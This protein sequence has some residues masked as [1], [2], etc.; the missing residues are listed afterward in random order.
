MILI[1]G[2]TSVSAAEVGNLSSQETSVTSSE[3]NS[4]SEE[5]GSSQDQTS[6]QVVTT[7]TDDQSSDIQSEE[8]SGSDQS[9]AQSTDTTEQTSDTSDTQSVSQTEDQTESQTEDQSVSQT[10]DQTAAQS[11][12]QAQE[13]SETQTDTQ[14]DE[15]EMPAQNFEQTSDSGIKVAVS[16]PEGAFP[17]GT[18]MEVADVS[19][20]T[21]MSIAKEGSD[22]PE[23]VVDA[24][25][26]D[27]TFK[28]K[29]GQE[30]E[31]ADGKDISVS[32]TLAEDLEGETFNVVHDDEQAGPTEIADAT[33]S[34]ASFTADSFSIYV[35]DGESPAIATY[36]FYDADGNLLT[37]TADGVTFSEQ[38]I[39]DGETLYSP[40]NPEKTGY[41]FQG[42]TT[43]QGSSTVELEP[44]SS[45]TPE[46]T[47]TQTI[48]YYP[49]FEEAHYVFFMDGT[50]SDARVYQTKSGVSG[51]EIDTT[52][53]TLPSA[54]TSSFTGWYTD[55]ALTN[56]AGD[57]VTL[58]SENIYLYPKFEEGHYLIF[59][60]GDDAT[61]IEPEFVASGSVTTEP[62]DP[63][64]AGY[65]FVGWSTTE[66][67]TTADFTF[68]SELTEDTT[69]YA[70][71]EPATTTYTVLFW[72]Q[73]VTD[74][75]NAADADKTYE[76]WTSATRTGTTESYAEPTSSDKAKSSVNDGVG[77]HF[78]ETNSVSVQIKGDGS[79][80]L[81]IYYDRDL[82]TYNFYS[83]GFSSTP[84]Y[85]I[86]GLYGATLKQSG[87]EWPSD[88]ETVWY[89][90]NGYYYSY[91]DD[92]QP[93]KDFTYSGNS[94]SIKFY[95]SAGSRTLKYY[96]ESV[97]GGGYTDSLT[98][99]TFYL[100]AGDGT[101]V[102]GGWNFENIFSGFTVSQF[103]V[104]DS[105]GNYGDWVSVSSDGSTTLSLN[106]M[107]YYS[108]HKS[109]FSDA[110]AY[111]SFG[112]FDVFYSRNQHSIQYYSGNELIHTESGIYYE[113]SLA[114]YG[115]DGDNYYVPEEAPSTVVEGSVF[116]GWY[117]DPECTVPYDFASATMPDDNVIVYAKWVE[118]T[119]NAYVYDEMYG[120]DL[121]DTIT[122]D[123]GGTVDENLMPNV[124][125]EDGNYYVY[126]SSSVTITI[127][128]DS[129]WIG[130]DV[131][132][133]D[134]DGNTTSYETYSF[135]TQLTEDIYL[136]PH[137]LVLNDYHITYD[138][139][140][141]TGTVTDSRNYAGGDDCYADVMS[142]SNLTPPEGKVFLYWNTAA[143]GSGTTYY[144][145]DQILMNSDV[146]LYAIYGDDPDA[147]N[148]TYYSNYPSDANLSEVTTKHTVNGETVLLN[149]QDLT[150]YTL[151]QASMST[152]DG[153]VFVGWNTAEDGS[154]TSYAAG[155]TI[156]VDVNDPQPNALYAIWV[157]EPTKD[158]FQSSDTSTS[159]DGDLVE[160]GDEL[161]YTITYTNSTGS[162]ATVTITDSIPE[163]ST[164]V[165][166]SAD[167]GGT[168]ADGT[169]TWNLTVADGDSI[170]VSF[171][172]TVDANNG[173]ALKN[174]ATVDDGTN[175]YT[176][177]ETTN[178]TGTNPTKDVFES[179]DTST[180]VD[181]DTVKAGDE[182]VYTITYTNTTGAD[183]T[184]DITD[185]IPD[186]ST[187]VDG[188]A[189][190][191]GTYADGTVTWSDI[192]LASGDS[193]TVSFSVTVDANDGTVLEND[194]DVTVGENT[195][196][197]NVTKNPTPT[198]PTKDVFSSD[199]T[200]TSID[201]NTVSEGDELVY[202]ITYTNTTGS[203]VTVT[204]TDAIPDNSTYVDGSA[205]NNGTYAD[206]TVTWSDISV[207]AGE[208]ITVSFS[209]TVDANDGT[210]VNNQATVSDGTNTYT[211]NETTNPTPTEP[212]KDVF[213]SSD[214]STSIDGNT[215]SEGDELVYKITYTNTT[216]A[217]ATVDIT[218]AIPDNSTYVDGSAD[219][220]GT[221]ADGTVTWSDIQVAA[222]DSIT[223][224]FKVTVN[225]DDGTA[226]K[227]QA[228]VDDG[229]NTYT[230][231]ETT[232]PT[233]TNPTK[234]VFE[235]TDT[236]TSVDGDTVKAGDELVYKITYTNTT[237]S[238]ATVDITDA[239]PDNST[240]VDGSADNNG[241][242]AD[243]TVTWSDISVAA[244]ESITVSFSVTVD[245]NDGTVLTN[246]ADV[247]VGENTYTTN[248][249]KNPTPTEP[250]K[251]VFK[252][253]DDTTSID[254]EEVNAGDEL[255]YKIT[256]TNTTGADATV[257]ITDEIP[258][259]STYV[260][261]S[262][263]NNG[264]YADGTLT[265]NLDV[266]NGE[267]ITVSFRVT[268]NSNDGE[269]LNNQATVNDGTNSYKTN[270]TTNPT[271]ETPVPSG[272]NATVNI[273]AKKLLKG[274]TLK[275]GQFTFEL[276]DQNGNTVQ[277]VKNSSDG[278]IS[279]DQLTFDKEGTWT[280]TIREVL[281]DDEDSS[282]DGIQKD[283]ITYDDT[284]YVV[285]VKV[286]RNADTGDLEASMTCHVYG[287]SEDSDL[288][289][290]NKVYNK[291][292]T[293]VT[294]SNPVKTGDNSN[295][296]LYL[297][298]LL[299]SAMIAAILIGRRRANKDHK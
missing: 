224:S 14:T 206:G 32:M 103:R 177:N 241:T 107:M 55:T 89:N 294:T 105:D 61:I 235:S 175:T 174:Q 263:D 43:T 22:T 20:D 239:I 83:S 9:A 31:P 193:I 92:F 42:W 191:N 297:T 273:S 19:S 38:R 226:L 296:A 1:Q 236:T 213:D 292:L 127:P 71:W 101:N 106:E 57:T 144:P 87:V 227:N 171:K 27:I 260:D 2:T 185:V 283:G 120:G 108:L 262:A 146:T 3:Q 243:G 64:R 79:T 52:D 126:T 251:D 72:K 29:D 205:D 58:G 160:A 39:K 267:S 173:T 110:Q 84:T 194:A 53:V 148:L 151:D 198:E 162:D 272:K 203:D 73:S 4:D 158:V 271:P 190:N 154:G 65:T 265:W 122:V 293:S 78:N 30:I 139:N 115:E 129:I 280:Y 17:E 56:E 269:E 143:D 278:S 217:D 204:I 270:E 247:T 142:G 116:A 135:D 274:G 290:T 12:S 132:V 222:G 231:N 44:F 41:I 82:I 166:G 163:N 94:A 179:T 298:L 187:Y 188:S 62:T 48:N 23:N 69:L 285:T 67:S 121:V 91:L 26:V 237:G 111:Y 102:F 95:K 169:V 201:G 50:E 21:A 200:E 242:Y 284:V 34:S 66:G 97:D 47:S 80:I 261:G 85:S 255:L 134:S 209:V 161:V 245:A 11:D 51:D 133:K 225:S 45:M 152:P 233:G 295:A 28:N 202:K 266:A 189:D 287:S 253:S 46:V 59:K 184:V 86:S 63:E 196:T 140:G 130:W 81:N 54:G 250:T 248:V 244:G 117:K 249:T 246:D 216:G 221:Y 74:N 167:N 37:Y 155:A 289:F 214:T 147:T 218:D 109:Y 178:P 195:Y 172:V 199:D 254:G 6:T 170:T 98:P 40:E 33:E 277:T 168:Y 197:T 156:G 157:K 238:D 229:T 164:Y 183:A 125:D 35:I 240:Y 7:A 113:A 268:V 180:S 114:D 112:G 93:V 256:Y 176:T 138:A 288:V 100:D 136:Y 24:V 276:R 186:N 181:G 25:G 99:Q 210:S 192:E 286:T 264:S 182:L 232:N 234:D 228:T 149:N 68:G 291:S 299:V 141:G 128:N 153:Y 131:A 219:N 36:R 16:A 279:F 49:V 159:I 60:T 15:T 230:T 212:T 88:E 118:P 207:A 75:I 124:V 13:Q 223:V 259:N 145:D 281:P 76:Y 119:V 70:V 282:I 275:D 258:A 8:D 220:G 215:V 104:M 5:D 208:S 211:T 77:F 252:S 96:K 150:V 10:E 165:T 257:T 137:Y 18:T 90:N 123:Y